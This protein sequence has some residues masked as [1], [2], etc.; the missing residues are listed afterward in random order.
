VWARDVSAGC[1]LRFMPREF[2]GAPD[3]G[4][5]SAVTDGLESEHWRARATATRRRSFEV[6]IREAA[7]QLFN[8][9]E[10]TETTVEASA[11]AAGVGRAIVY[12]RFGTKAAIVAALVEEGL[13]PGRAVHELSCGS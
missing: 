11:E 7:R 13:R 4:R 9:V 12:N 8:D 6:R 1:S 2:L 3:H 5:R 10:F